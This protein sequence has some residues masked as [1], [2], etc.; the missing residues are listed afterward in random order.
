MNAYC[1]LSQLGAN[2]VFWAVN[3][4]TG[5]YALWG[6]EWSKFRFADR[7]DITQSVQFF[8]QTS[9]LGNPAHYHA[10]LWNSVGFG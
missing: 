10:N 2:F 6:E 1:Q 7:S 4:Q 5:S 8:K 3:R 9:D